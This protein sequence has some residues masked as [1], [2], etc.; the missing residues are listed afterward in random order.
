MTEFMLC[1]PEAEYLV[2]GPERERET[3]KVREERG[4]GQEGN[5]EGCGNSSGLSPAPYN[6]S[7]KK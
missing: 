7:P 2:T 3:E 5:G 1:K 4:G 6:C